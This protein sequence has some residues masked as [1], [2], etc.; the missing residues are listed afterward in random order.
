MYLTLYGL[1][2]VS[3]T[4]LIGAILQIEAAEEG[5]TYLTLTRTF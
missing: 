1:I 5:P 3:E 2:E 4:A